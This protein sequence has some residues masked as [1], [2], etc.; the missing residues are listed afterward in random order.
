MPRLDVTEQ[1]S[2][3]GSAAYDPD[4]VVR[5]GPG[6]PSFRD[7]LHVMRRLPRFWFSVALCSAASASLA[8]KEGALSMLLAWAIGAVGVLA[9]YPIW[10]AIAVRSPGLATEG[11]PELLREQPDRPMSPTEPPSNVRLLDE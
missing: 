4:V 5:G 6:R 8:L 11:H 3:V 2:T 9:F 10:R 1:G 7:Y